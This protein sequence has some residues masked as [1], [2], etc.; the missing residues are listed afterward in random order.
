MVVQ[1][2]VKIDVV[3]V[4]AVEIMTVV[5]VQVERDIVIRVEEMVGQALMIM[6]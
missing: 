1:E 5:I 3:A 2:Q 6:T 4:M